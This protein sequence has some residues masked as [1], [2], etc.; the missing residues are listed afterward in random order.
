VN[1]ELAFLSVALCISASLV[2][3]PV[4]MA[5]WGEQASLSTERVEPS[6]IR[7]GTP[8]LY[9]ERLS[10]PARDAVRAAIESPDGD[11]TVYG[12]EDWPGRF[13]FSD[14]IGPGDGLYVIVYEG[15]RYSL[16]T[17]STG[18]FPF[19]FWLYELPFIAY[20]LCVGW[21]ARRV[22][23]GHPVT[24]GTTLATG[25]GALFHLLGPEFDFPL[26]APKQFV[27]VGTVACLVLPVWLRLTA[28]RTDTGPVTE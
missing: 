10:E 11:H 20:G 22:F 16:T 3:A 24:R 1:R 23:L 2:G 7:D 13:T 15:Q 17:Y 18:T 6:D 4:T 8:T 5:D 28:T 26:V 14:S 9:Y 27:A 12:T 21:L 25:T 19:V